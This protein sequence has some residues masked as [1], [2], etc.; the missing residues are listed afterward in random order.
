M[1]MVAAV[2]EALAPHGIPAPVNVFELGRPSRYPAWRVLFDDTAP[3]PE[4]WMRG[5]PAAR[6]R[7]ELAALGLAGRASLAVP[8]AL[9][10]D[11]RELPVPV[12]VHR[13]VRGVDA[14]T[15]IVREPSR[16][17]EILTVLGRFLR[18]LSRVGADSWGRVSAD[19]RTFRPV[20]TTWREEWRH[21][22]GRVAERA[23]ELGPVVARVLSAVD[24]RLDALDGAALGLV[25]G[26]LVPASFILGEEE[27]TLFVAGVLDWSEA[28]VGDR[29][30]DVV[31]ILRERHAGARAAA[32]QAAGHTR[33]ELT[34]PGVLARLEVYDLTRL[35]W[36]AGGAGLRLR[37]D[38]RE[39]ADRLET[40]HQA[41]DETLAGG[42][43]GRILAA[44]PDATHIDAWPTPERRLL[45][46]TAV[47]ARLEPPFPAREA[48]VV[49][50]GIAAGLMAGLDEALA[51]HGED[52]LDR[53][54][55][56]RVAAWHPA[57]QDREAWARALVQR[58]LE[59][60]LPSFSLPATWFALEAL[61]RLGDTVDHRV[62]GGFDAHLSA[63][64][65]AEV[66]SSEPQ[67]RLMLAVMGEAAV[68]ELPR[69][70]PGLS[71]L[72]ERQGLLRGLARSA[73]ARL[74]P[75]PANQPWEYT[76]ASA[77][78]YYLEHRAE[79]REHDILL[80]YLFAMHTLGDARL[81]AGPDVLLVLAG[82]L[83]R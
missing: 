33:D 66:P 73:L 5:T 62:L 21:H 41:L 28:C 23:S 47:L 38:G 39:L 79:G 56:R 67:L 16:R 68:Q 7:S 54:G 69:L 12:V 15:R 44:S 14:A 82:L 81:P 19:G 50:A 80:A 60:P 45:R 49:M 2:A 27:G 61:E 75:E 58:A 43:R 26:D 37:S 55:R 46:R 11:A 20:W 70:V 71:D 3:V 25:H 74:F 77:R 13:P 4:L 51:S 6:L 35:L 83:A 9:F 1:Q 36:Q 63:L 8:D 34:E 18:S 76:V 65:L 30:I 31:P 59:V 72:R 22:V 57:V 78:A 24:A 32:L 17:V 53:L 42:L 40:V 29:L 10:V 52:L 64:R 48:P